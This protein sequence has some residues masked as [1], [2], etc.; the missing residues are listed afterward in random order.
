MFPNFK[1]RRNPLKHEL[2]VWLLHFVP[3]LLMDLRTVLLRKKKLR[4]VTPIA[5]KFRQACLAGKQEEQ[6][7]GEFL[8]WV[9]VLQYQSLP[10]QSLCRQFLF[11]Q[12]VDLQESQS[13]LL[14]AADRE[15]NI[16][17]ALLESG[18]AQLR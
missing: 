13:I 15:Q 10:N 17:H 11:A 3:A 7:K 8:K 1:Y 12:R 9:P 5:A 14:P 6:W 18:R 16:C 2:A 4:F